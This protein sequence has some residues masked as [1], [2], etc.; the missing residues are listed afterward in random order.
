MHFIIPRT[1][2]RRC[3]T[4][5]P[6][7]LEQNTSNIRSGNH[8]NHDAIRNNKGVVISSKTSELQSKTAINHSQNDERAAVPDVE[9]ADDAALLMPE[10]VSVV[11]VTQEGL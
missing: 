5:R 3:S 11:E 6:P 8:G 7:H 9:V 4:S 10:I 2:R 1:S